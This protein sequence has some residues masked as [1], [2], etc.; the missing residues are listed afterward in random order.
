MNETTELWQEML[1]AE[2][3]PGKREVLQRFFKTG[4]GEYGEGDIFLGITVPSVRKVSRLMS[5]VPFESIAEMLASG[6]HEHRLSALLVLVEQFRRARRNPETRRAIVDFY[7]AHTSAVNNWDLVDLSAPKIL[8]EFVSSTAEVSLLHRLSNSTDL[9]EQRIAI[10]ATWTLLRDG[11]PRPTL[12]ISARYLTHT[13]D[14]IHKATGWMLREMGKRVDQRLLTDFLD[15]NAPK[16]PRT[17]LGYAI[18]KLPA[19]LRHH[20]LTIPRQSV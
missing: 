9:W 20:Y 16:M 14:L 8:G 2:I 19:P 11:E 7:L 5:E 15:I 18:E 6:I 17:M 12:E 10:V 4:P 1:R 3:V 13:H